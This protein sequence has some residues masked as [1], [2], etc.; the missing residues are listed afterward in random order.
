MPTIK[1]GSLDLQLPDAVDTIPALIGLLSMQLERNDALIQGWGTLGDSLQEAAVRAAVAEERLAGET[2][3]ADAEKQR[4][5]TA[6]SERATDMRWHKYYEGRYS[7]VTRQFADVKKQRDNN[8]DAYDN[9]VE[10]HATTRDELGRIRRQRNL[11][12]VLLVF[13]LLLWLGF[14]TRPSWWP[15]VLP[16]PPTR[17]QVS[18]LESQ[19]RIL[20]GDNVDLRDTIRNLNR[21]VGRLSAQRTA[22]TPTPTTPTAASATRPRPSVTPIPSGVSGTPTPTVVPPAATLSATPNPISGTT[23]TKAE[24]E[25]LRADLETWKSGI[26]NA[27]NELTKQADHITALYNARDIRNLR[28]SSWPAF[29]PTTLQVIQTPEK[30][31]VGLLRFVSS[32]GYRYLRF[33]D[34]SVFDADTGGQATGDGYYLMNFTTDDLG[35]ITQV[36]LTRNRAISR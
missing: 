20:A 10:A 36:Y 7:E 27:N 35:F 33:N 2:R 4:A 5:D 1:Y 18:Q 22:E 34:L 31:H 3:R 12:A 25:A 24:V 23:A 16:F 28:P 30:N 8:K 11:L 15:D 26:L 9:E 32:D 13:I 19:N 21:E 6:E 17:A 14:I 29:Y